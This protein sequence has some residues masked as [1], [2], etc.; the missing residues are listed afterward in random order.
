MLMSAS[1]R[2]KAWL[3]LLCRE[4]S[5]QF[6]LWTGHRKTL[7]CPDNMNNKDVYNNEIHTLCSN[8]HA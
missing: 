2:W 6:I 5:W 4:K 3:C 8:E 7:E 1:P